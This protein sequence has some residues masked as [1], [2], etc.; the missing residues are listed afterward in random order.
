MFNSQKVVPEYA[1]V[2]GWRQDPTGEII[3][4][5]SL[6][7]TETGE[8]FQQKHPALN[9][10]YINTLISPNLSIDTY[11]RNVVTDATNEIF[12]DVLQYRKVKEFGKTLL[13]QSTLLNSYGWK[14]DVITN[15]N[16]F[17]GMQIKVKSLSGL[18]AVINEI[19]LQ[20]LGVQTLTLHLFHSS[21]KSALTTI[22]IST[23]GG[24]E[25]K[26]AKTDLELNAF[27]SLEYHGGVFII[28]YY[29]ED[30]T[31]S[32]INY[33]NFDWSVGE[34]Q[35][36]SNSYH[37]IW[38]SIRSFFHVHPIYVP[39]GSFVKNEMFDLNDMIY[40]NDQSWGLNF[41]FSV[42][43]DLT[44]FF[45]S[46]KHEFKNLLSLKVVHNIL[47]MMKFSQ[48]INQIEQNIKNMIIRDLEGDIDTK[49]TNIPTQY[50]RELKAVSFS[51]SAINGSCLP[52]EDKGYAPD[53]GV[54]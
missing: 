21:K 10:T 20:L 42:K 50:Q 29:Q 41:K 47:N 30:L 7:D 36:C 11:L 5:A 1:N 17:V 2:L 32:A 3:L 16:R 46:N 52:C 51:T 53:Y 40:T 54:I 24:A 44:D 15:Q 14:N 35:T 23:V 25:W 37:S 22:D 34:C 31:T 9:V 39:S 18:K 12:N 33:T 43:C 27:S 45:I 8:Y 13:E 28:G 19:G 6:T 49:L 26:W 48:E 38:K 4:P